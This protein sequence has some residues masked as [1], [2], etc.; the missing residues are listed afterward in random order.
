ML[1]VLEQVADFGE[2]FFFCRWFWFWRRSGRFF[3]LGVELCDEADEEEDAES[4][5]EEV[6]GALDEVAVSHSYFRNVFALSLFQYPFELGEVYAASD[7]ADNRHDD[8]VNDRCYDFAE[9]AADDNTDS[10]VE[11]VATHGKLLEVVK[12]CTFHFSNM[13][14]YIMFYLFRC[15]AISCG[16]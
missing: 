8:V 6:N 3:L 14:S 1:L 10:H 12:K 5:D 7:D 15:R 2:Q 13:C 9:S 4:D 16:A 11:H